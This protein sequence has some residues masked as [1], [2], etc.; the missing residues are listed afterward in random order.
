M[1]SAHRLSTVMEADEILVLDENG[2]VSDRGQHAELIEREGWYRATWA[3]QQRRIEL[4][5]EP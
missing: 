2:Q 3:Q 4:E 1:V 5:V